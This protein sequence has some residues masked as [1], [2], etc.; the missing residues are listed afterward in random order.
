MR[1]CE[2]KKVK[3]VQVFSG[4]IDGAVVLVAR[5]REEL[6][7]ELLT[8]SHIKK[9][10]HTEREKERDRDT[11][12]TLHNIIKIRG[13]GGGGG[14]AATAFTFYSRLRFYACVYIFV[15][16]EDWDWTSHFRREEKWSFYGAAA[17]AAAA[18]SVFL[19]LWSVFFATFMHYTVCFSH[20]KYFYSLVSYPRGITLYN[21][22]MSSLT[23]L[24]GGSRS[25]RGRSR[26]KRMSFTD[27]VT[28]ATQ[29]FT[30]KST[31]SSQKRAI[32][33]CPFHH[34][35]PSLSPSLAEYD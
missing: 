32:T 18:C 34:I 5:R 28:G 25:S 7:P 3:Q 20:G 11:L 23:A 22:I 13:G 19:V 14:G 24:S 6:T 26:A 29:L 21:D 31:S 17:A 2:L 9:Y 27:Q 15:R 12:F 30:R 35:S 16:M 33:S 8:Q 1:W 4:R 10:I